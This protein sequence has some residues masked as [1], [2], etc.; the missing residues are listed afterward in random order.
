MVKRV[1]IMGAAGRDFHNFNVYYRDNPAYRIVAFTATQIPFIQDRTYPP[2]LSGPLYPDGIPIYPEERLPELMKDERI[3]EVVFSYSDVSHTY[4]MHRASMVTAMGGN[5]VL[6]GSE[7]TMLRSRRPVV[8]ICAV[9]T[10]CGKS[11][12]TRMVAGIL[13]EKERKTVVI[14]HPM[15]YRDLLLQKVQ[16]FSSLKDVVGSGCTIEEME[17]FEPLVEA[18]ITV[19]AGVDYGE[20]LKRAEEEA[21]VIVW[22]G[23]NNDTPFL[24]PDLEIC[25]VDPL[26]PGDELSYYPGEVNLIRADCVVINKTNTA[27]RGDVERVKKNIHSLNPSC[28]I[29]ETASEISVSDSIEGKKVLVVEDGPTLTHGGMTYG[30]GIVAAELYGAEVVDPVPYAIG[31]IRETLSAYPGLK[32]LLPAMGYSKGQIE[33]LEQTINRTPCD[34][35]LVATPVNLGAILNIDKP[36]VRVYYE[37]RDITTPGLKGIIDDFLK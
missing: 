33:E 36:C 8:S 32:R 12:V 14:R 25:I 23:G 19:Y 35:V 37:V 4:I 24:R 29:V 5:F 27:D 17:E 16:R 3:D 7:K 13:I 20:I 34:L 31:S 22:D 30:A 1:I 15:P 21:Q 28:T 10:G 6:L 18:G 2:E 9:R 26:R 11:G